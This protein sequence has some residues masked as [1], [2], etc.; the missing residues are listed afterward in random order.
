MS[1]TINILVLTKSRKNGGFCVA[2]IDMN[3][4]K[5]VR[6]IVSIPPVKLHD[7][8]YEDG[9]YCEPL[10]VIECSVSDPT[11]PIE[12]QPENI[13]FSPP[14]KL[15]KKITLDC[16]KKTIDKI[17][18]YDEDFIFSNQSCALF[19]D[20]VR[21]LGRSLQ[22]A[23]VTN[24]T[25]HNETNLNG[26][27]KTKLDFE[28]KG[29]KYSNFSITDPNFYNRKNSLARAIIVFSLPGKADICYCKFVAKIFPLE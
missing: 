1:D 17:P 21:K 22:I 23:E 14:I 26:L 15:V 2:G 3:T 27:S 8:K 28:Y 24:L 4:M 19:L 25:F 13:M 18:F 6:L 12:L 10:D 7:L 9:Q 20:D 5:W 16:L 11:T 29:K